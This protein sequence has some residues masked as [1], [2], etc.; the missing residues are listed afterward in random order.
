MKEYIAG[1]DIGGT[2]VK[3]A[4]FDKNDRESG[5]IDKWEIVTRGRDEIELLWQ[6]LADSIR[7]KM[8]ALG[9]ADEELKAAGM[10]LPGPIREDGFLPWCVNLGMGACYPAKELEQCLG[11]P[12][13][14][15]NDANVAALGEVYYGVAKGY[16]NAAL[17]TLGTGL[18][19][20]II[21]N[22]KII[23]GNRG[24]AGEVGHFVV[25]PDEQ[26]T[27]NCGNRGCLE[28]YCSATGMVRVARRLLD[29][30]EDPST[31]RSIKGFSAKDV[32]DEARKG[33]AIASEVIDTFGKYM[34]LACSYIIETMDPDVFIVGGGVSRAGKLLTD[35]MEKWIDEY[36][37][38]A[39]IKPGV[40]LATPETMPAPT[41]R[42]RWLSVHYSN[43]RL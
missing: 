20:G 14:A 33:D 38:V 42:Q 28:Q 43:K 41:A 18:G 34:G 23:A 22:G 35:A 16:E 32:C 6:D 39:Q 24:L 17:F 4:L 27:C 8:A 10:G 25:N 40:L 13:A 11:V 29:K 36:S 9:I 37:H 7:E 5:A 3:L 15:G 1:I 19:G 31:L 12:V 30:K 2:T 26:E 21:Q